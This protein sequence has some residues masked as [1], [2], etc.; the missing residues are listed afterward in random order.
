ME[1]GIA[2]ELE[3]KE[4]KKLDCDDEQLSLSKHEKEN[5][6]KTV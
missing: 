4:S 6:H 2:Q 3:K 1:I 5:G